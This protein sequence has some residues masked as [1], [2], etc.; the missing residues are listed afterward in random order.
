MISLALADEHCFRKR[1][2][3]QC[4]PAA[5]RAGNAL[6]KDPGSAGIMEQMDSAMPTGPWKG[7][8]LSAGLAGMLLT[9][10]HS[11]CYR[12]GQAQLADRLL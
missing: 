6:D 8:N 9:T 2:D 10:R 1:R 4:H 12:L 11:L 7:G 3:P 5:F